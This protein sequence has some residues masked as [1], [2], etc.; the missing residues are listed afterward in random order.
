MLHYLQVMLMQTKAPNQVHIHNPHHNDIHYICADNSPYGIFKRHLPEMLGVISDTERLANDLSS[1]DLISYLVK[2]NVLTT[3]LS[4]YQKASKLLNE[5]ER[6]LLVINK[7]ET[8]TSYCEVL[9]KQM[10]PTLTRIAQ[11]ILMELS[12]M[13][14]NNHIDIL[15]LST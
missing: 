3:N 2:D 6:S 11:N 8:L 12:E 14:I 13:I 7:S 15:L 5:I 4:R 9:K 10:N 1:A